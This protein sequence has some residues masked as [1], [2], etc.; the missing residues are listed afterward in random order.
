L[1]NLS[2]DTSF[3]VSPP[4]QEIYALEKFLPGIPGS[5]SAPVILTPQDWYTAASALAQAML[6][7]PHVHQLT[8]ADFLIYVDTTQVFF[9]TYAFSAVLEFDQAWR[10][11][12]RAR[13]QKWTAK[14]SFLETRHLLRKVLPPKTLPKTKTTSTTP[15]ASPLV[16]HDFSKSSCSRLSACRYAH[17][18]KLCK[19]TF[20]N[21]FGKC[22][23][24]PEF[25]LPACHSLWE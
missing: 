5:K 3:W 9:D 15:G 14:N 2:T 12:R 17:K 4:N 8:F 13:A 23:W 25:F 1:P 7:D 10:R 20:P 11:W 6:V 24:L 18:C 22:M 21:T 19:T 16:C